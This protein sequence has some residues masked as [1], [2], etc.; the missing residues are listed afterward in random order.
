MKFENH[1]QHQNHEIRSVLDRLVDGAVN[2]LDEKF[3]GAW[4]Q[5]SMATGHFD[6][7]SDIDFV[8]GI[9]HDLTEEELESLQEFHKRLYNFESPWSKHLEGSYIPRYILADYNRAG[10]EVWYLDHGSTIFERSDHDNTIAVKWIVREKGVVLAGPEPSEIMVP[11][12]I[13]ELQKDVY[14]TF[15]KW[16]EVIVQDHDVIGSHFYQTFAV[17]SY[18][19]MLPAIRSGEIGSK[20]DG[21]EWAKAN[22]DPRWHD[23]IDR[24]W[25]GRHDPSTSSK[26]PA[27]PE[28]LEQTIEF[29]KICLQEARK[30]LRSFGHDPASIFDAT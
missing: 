15:A 18:A 14:R 21:S 3:L 13:P 5:G 6:E 25:L 20:Q 16:A 27:D 11:I 24:S 9:E 4:L 12:P 23:L 30:I 2:I 7:H 28:D 1:P 8:I 10:E 26:R 19:R 17:L 29:I 22:L